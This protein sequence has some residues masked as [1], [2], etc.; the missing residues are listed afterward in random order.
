MRVI[1]ADA[2]RKK[3]TNVYDFQAS[4]H[5]LKLRKNIAVSIAVY[6]FS[7]KSREVSDGSNKQYVSS[8]P[9]KTDWPAIPAA[10]S[11]TLRRHHCDQFYITLYPAILA[12]A[13]TWASFGL[14]SAL[15]DMVVRHSP[16]PSRAENVQLRRRAASDGHERRLYTTE[17]V[18]RRDRCRRYAEEKRS[19][20]R[21]PQTC[22]PAAD[23]EL[24]SPLSRR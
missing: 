24:A 11:I 19:I 16:T 2:R 18:E 7:Y 9:M 23:V 10:R 13:F 15:L 5:A 20:S 4:H 14:D 12:A 1:Y 3:R 8:T 21:R 17:V 6:L 22:P